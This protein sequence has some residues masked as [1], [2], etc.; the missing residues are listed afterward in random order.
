VLQRG[1]TLVI[2]AELMDV[3]NGWQLWG[4]RYKRKF[5]DI[6]DVQ[7]EIAKVIFEKLRV[8]LSPAEEKRLTKRYT[9]DAEAYQLYLKGVHLWNKWTKEGFRKAEQFFQ[10]AIEADPSYAPAYAGLADAVAAP[11]YVGL[12]PPRVGIPKSKAMVQK[13]LA[14]DDS[15]P[16]AWF[17]TGIT[18]LFYDWDFHLAEQAFRRVVELDPGYSRG[19]EGVGM[20]LSMMGRF[21]EGMQALGQAAKL[22]PLRTLVVRHIGLINLWMNKNREACEELRKSLEVD[23]GFFLSRIDLGKAHALNGNYSEAIRE[24]ERAVADSGENPYA[25]GYLGYALARAGER[26]R[27]E[28][29][30]QQFHELACKIYV[31]AYATSLVNLGLGETN[32]ALEWLEKAF[33]DREP[34]IAELKVDPIFDPLR[35]EPRFQ[36]ML[37][38]MNFPEQ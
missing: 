23:P 2:A 16:L 13:A 33:E 8:K 22:E 36:D 34:R 26:E 7:E 25:V 5:D 15:V 31:P 32:A 9:E 30:L 37:R 29:A 24:L 3:Q 14:F 27:A 12:V 38:R 21:E 18:R 4:E 10:L 11:T 6:F 19:H 17:V 1:D 28:K 20:T 35:S